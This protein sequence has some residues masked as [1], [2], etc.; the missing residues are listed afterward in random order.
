MTKEIKLLDGTKLS[1]LGIGSWKMGDSFSKRKEELESIKYALDN[2]IKLIDTAEM[3][4]NGN[5]EKLIGEAIKGYDRDDL[6]LV[7]KVL[8]SNAGKEYIF[9]SCE[10]SLKRMKIDY[11]DLYLLHW[12]GNTPLKETEECMIK[13]IK[14]GKIK[15]WGVSNMDIDD[16][17]E[18]M[19]LS[20]ENSCMVNQVLYHLG[21]RGIE[22]SL[23]PYTDKNNII[24]MAYCP[25][26]Q[27]GKLRE[28][29]LSSVSIIK[30][31]KKY[32]ISPVQ[33]LLSYIMTKENTVSIPK[34]SQLVHMK[35]IV[36]CK[37]II[38][39]EEDIK[40]LES[41]FPKPIKKVPLDVE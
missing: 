13:L 37:N 12:R 17:E 25:I 8:P 18:I 27:A 31:S 38:L 19:G 9:K 26:A 29:L 4:G 14:D 16:M 24:T 35:E 3:Y 20:T 34:S 32:N 1:N 41:E 21:S 30:V 2:G 40:I 7:S 22:F 15:R 28:K 6:F 11:L 5:S 33:V 23:K 39:L 36:D 10:N